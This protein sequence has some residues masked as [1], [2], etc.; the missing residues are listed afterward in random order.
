MELKASDQKFRDNLVTLE[1]QE[2]GGSNKPLKYFLMTIEY[3]YQWYKDGA[4]GE[5]VCLDK[6]RL[7]DFAG[8]SIEHIYPRNVSE[9]DQ[10]N[11]LDQ[12]KNSLGNLTI[13]DTAQNSIGGNEN[14]SNKKPLYQKSSVL[15]TQEIGSKTAW[16]KSEIEAHQKLLIDAAVAIFRL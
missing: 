12:L 14:F 3:Y 7:Y 2:S 10:D 15:L 1:Y 6:S 9:S 5:S 4:S 16:T 11:E 8:T 13:L